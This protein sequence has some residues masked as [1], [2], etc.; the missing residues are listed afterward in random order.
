MAAGLDAFKTEP[1]PLESPLQ[2]L[3]NVLLAPHM[4]GLDYESQRDMSTKAAQCIV[5]LYQG[6]WP[7]ECVVN[8]QLRPGWKW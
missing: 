2:K 4:G 1:L 8:S 3:D 5:D 6:R 7:D